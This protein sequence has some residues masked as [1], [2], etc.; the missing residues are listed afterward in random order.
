MNKDVIYFITKEI[1]KLYDYLAKNGLGISE[2]EKNKLINNLKQLIKQESELYS[3][4][5]FD[6]IIEVREYFDNNYD[7]IGLELAERVINKLDEI[8]LDNDNYFNEFSLKYNDDPEYNED[9]IKFDRNTVIYAKALRRDLFYLKIY[10]L[11]KFLNNYGLISSNI[12][13]ND[14][15]IK[16][17]INNTIFKHCSYYSNIENEFIDNN[18]EINDYYL[19]SNL[20]KQLSLFSPIISK[21]VK[22][23]VF[24]DAFIDNL[25]D[26]LTVNEDNLYDIN[27]TITLLESLVHILSTLMLEKDFIVQ[28]N[29][30]FENIENDLI[31][32]LFYD[33]FKEL[34][35]DKNKVKLLSLN[36]KFF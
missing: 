4:L 7:Q 25:N 13:I 15:L 9:D 16:K 11:N 35:K 20:V 12:G 24:E 17:S 8:I 34:N 28:I 22:L 30:K 6:D 36:D 19:N 29:N 14:I 5:T 1:N 2:K 27:N 32:Y 21:T 18:Y 31:Y 33:N 26:I 10:F 23:E 3:Y